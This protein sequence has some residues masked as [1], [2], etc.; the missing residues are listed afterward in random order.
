MLSVVYSSI[1]VRPFDDEALREL[2]ATSRAA[3]E[4]VD[5]TGVLFF[6]NGYFLQLLEGPDAAVLDK[7]ATIRA[8]PRHDKVTTLLKEPIVERQFPEWTMAYASPRDEELAAV[9]GYRTVLAE[10]EL[11][12]APDAGGPGPALRELV[13]WFQAHPATLS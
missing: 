3:N 10:L 9:P 1:A 5:V 6:K 2:L 13:R 7:M 4:R 11:D 8:D 12:G